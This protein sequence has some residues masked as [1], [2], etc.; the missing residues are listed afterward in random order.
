MKSQ[1]SDP[2]SKQVSGI[3]KR[4]VAIANDPVLAAMLA[5]ERVESEDLDITLLWK[6][7]RYVRPHGLITSISIALSI[8][9]SLLMTLPAYVI[10]LAL[11]HI[12]G[13]DRDTQMI[14]GALGSL[15]EWVLGAV[16]ASGQTAL[17]VYFGGVVAVAWIL[18][19]LLAMTTTYLVQIL[20]QKVVHDLRVDVYNH[21][22]RMSLDYFHK[23]P[24]G[25]LVNR[26]TFDVQA[27][28]ELF[29]NAF[30][31][32]LRD[33]VFIIV[34]TAVMFALDA[35]LAAI[36][37]GTFPLLVLVA[38]IYRY[39][40]RPSLRTL[41]AVQ[42]RMNSWLAENLSGMRE[43]QLYR[44][45]ERRRAEYRSLTEAH[46]TAW[47][48]V[49]QAWGMM[50][51]AMMAVTAVGTAIVLLVGYDRVLAGLIT[52]GVL[53]TFLQYTAR[54]WVPI[55][56]LT[57]KINVIQN[58][59]TAG[60][61]IFDVLETPSSMV[62]S[63]D[64]DQAT[65]VERGAVKFDEVRFSYP[66]SEQEVLRGISFEA[67]PGDLIALVGD[68]GAGKTTIVSLLSRFYDVDSGHVLVDGRDVRDYTLHNLRRGIALVPQDVVVF[69]GTL[70]D[71]ITLGAEVD[72]ELIMDCM[73]AVCAEELVYRFDEGLDHVLE[74]SGRTLSA[75]ERQLLSFARA[76]LVN[77]PILILDE[78]TASIDTRTEIKIQQ[79]LDEL[80]RGRTTIVIAHR[81]STIRDADLILV[82]RDGEVI[83]RGTH[84]ELLILDDEYARLHRKHT[85]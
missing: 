29:S 4:A 85:S 65:E 1:S 10:G 72:D 19:W 55:R 53:L 60:E 38:Y 43:N 84:E 56:N 79:A 11:D 45:E 3:E 22:T 66:T 16:G 82:L 14:D 31:Q 71:N 41:Q 15:G 70:R 73:R 54:L 36:L 75:G 35:P 63:P 48:R 50:R 17:I 37:V 20:G 80:T 69:A 18:R 33:S 44:R 46:Q 34:L 76:L 61:R 74:E 27:L 59:L 67:S 62:D 28:S 83:E 25:R 23:N 58:A 8:V 24:V 49:I 68:T 13:G 30:A 32:G 40:A 51:P 77:P 81:L 5:E 47:V 52:V 12:T 21:V 42:S 7:M 2:S 39:L 78:A 6:L 64:A 26:T 9:E 57:E